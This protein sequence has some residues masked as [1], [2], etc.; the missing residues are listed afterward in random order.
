MNKS[1]FFLIILYTFPST[2]IP[3]FSYYFIYIIFHL[4][5]EQKEDEKEIN[6]RDKQAFFVGCT[7]IKK[8]R[9]FLISHKYIDKRLKCIFIT[10][11]KIGPFFFCKL[12]D[13]LNENGFSIKNMGVK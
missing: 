3:L 2:K 9:K 6:S 8:E 13:I 5:I 12:L 7:K 11:I 1:I 4:S 10:Q